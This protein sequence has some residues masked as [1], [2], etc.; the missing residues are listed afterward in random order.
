MFFIL[1]SVRF[2]VLGSVPQSA[3]VIGLISVT[4]THRKAPSGAVEVVAVAK[5]H[6]AGAEV[7]EPGKPRIIVCT[8]GPY[9]PSVGFQKRRHV[10]F[11]CALLIKSFKLVQS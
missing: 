10:T 9:L 6:L 3:P 2:S 8:G 4:E 5:E 1:P 11:P 7:K